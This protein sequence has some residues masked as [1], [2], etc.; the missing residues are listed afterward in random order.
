MTPP[1]NS[2]RRAMASTTDLAYLSLREASSLLGARKVSPVE[3][4][5]ACIARADALE[6]RLNAYITRTFDTSRHEARAAEVEIAA[7]RRNGPLHG[8]PF[9]IKDLYET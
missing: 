8:V 2:R 7:G 1:T 3:L 9:A 5:E 4:T 6:P